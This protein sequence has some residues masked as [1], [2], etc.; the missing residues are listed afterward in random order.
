VEDPDIVVDCKVWVVA[1]NLVA[2]AAAAAV[3]I[4]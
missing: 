3:E 1:P 2:F 4:V